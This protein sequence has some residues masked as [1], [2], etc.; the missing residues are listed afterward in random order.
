MQRKKFL[1][2]TCMVAI[3]VGVFG[4]IRWSNDR[5]VGDTP[6]TTDILGPFY[7]P[8]APFRTNIN[9]AGYSGNM[10]HL[11][12]TV[13]KADGKTPFKNCLVEIWQCDANKVYDNTS[14]EYKYRGAQKTDAK[15]KYHFITSHPVPYKISEQS[16]DYRPAHI[17]MRISGEG[18]QDLVTQVYFKGDPYLEKDMYS[19][20]PRAASRI[21]PITKN[22]KNEE[23]VQFDVVMAKEFK[24][25][26]RVFEQ[27]CGVYEMNNHVLREYYRDGDS[28]FTKVNGQIMSVLTYKGNNEFIS[29]TGFVVRFELQKD[30]GVK[31]CLIRPDTKECAETGIKIRT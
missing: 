28:L 22:N 4:S 13:F 7:R 14:D 10:F 26:D 11:S 20:S 23:M 15:G 27:I 24:P 8:N 2:D 30:G 16:E 18:Q 5:F 3:G 17:H 19:S 25:S 6:T 29:A 12:G 9:P 31:V 1:K 21:I